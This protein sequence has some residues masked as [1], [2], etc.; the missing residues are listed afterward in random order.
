MSAT[1]RAE[2]Y[3]RHTGRYGPEL[4]AAFVRFVGIEP[5]MRCLTWAVGPAR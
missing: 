4:S 3:D 2:A 1:G 5:E